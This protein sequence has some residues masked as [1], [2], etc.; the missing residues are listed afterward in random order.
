MLLMEGLYLMV[1]GMS[2]VFC[3]LLL[4]VWTMLGSAYF[5]K[6]FSTYFPDEPQLPPGGVKNGDH[7]AEIAVALA[8]VKAFTKN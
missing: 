3:F 2:V 1:V 7:Y 6:K 5:F 8:A 4:L